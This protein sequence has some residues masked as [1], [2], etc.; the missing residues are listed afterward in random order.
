MDDGIVVL[1]RERHQ[2][3]C[4]YIETLERAAEKVPLLAQQFHE[5]VLRLLLQED[6]YKERDKAFENLR[7]AEQAMQKPAA[8]VAIDMDF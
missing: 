6:A 1:R 5:S 2:A 4:D 3:W 7:L 8:P